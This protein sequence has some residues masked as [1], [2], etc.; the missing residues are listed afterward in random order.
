MSHYTLPHIEPIKDSTWDFAKGQRPLDQLEKKLG[1][2]FRNIELLAQALTHD[3]SFMDWRNPPEPFNKGLEWVGDAVI[4]LAICDILE[5]NFGKNEVVERLLKW[6]KSNESLSQQGQ[7]LNITQWLRI[8]LPNFQRY[9]KE[10]WTARLN[11]DAYEAVLGA[12]YRDQGM[13]AVQRVVESW[14]IPLSLIKLSP[15]ELD[16]PALLA[17]YKVKQRHGSLPSFQ[18]TREG[19]RYRCQLRHRQRTL[20]SGH[21]DDRPQSIYWA[22]KNYLNSFLP[23]R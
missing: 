11:G 8:D 14:V 4:Q 17:N 21:G 9:R 18:T 23:G 5:A 1:V 13:P 19:S 16:Q 15:T 2:R 10:D 7:L 22:A 6:F 20:S 3:S 12:L